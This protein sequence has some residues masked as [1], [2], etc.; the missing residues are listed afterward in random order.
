MATFTITS[1]T[2]ID[3]L[4]GKAGD[5]TYNVN[6]GKLTIDQDSLYGKNGGYI[7][8][9]TIGSIS[10]GGDITIDGRYI[11]LIPYNTGSGNVP[12]YN[13]TI[14]QGSSSGI[15]IGV[16]SALNAAP[17]TPGS[18]MP[19]S[20]YIK[21]KQWNS[22]AYTAG[23]LTGISANATAADVAGW[24]E[25]IGAET[26]TITINGLNNLTTPVISGEWYYIG[27][28]PGTPARTDTYQIPTN[29]NTCFCPGVFVET[30][31]GSGVYKIWHSTSDTATVDKV[32]TDGRGQRVC[33]VSSG[34]VLRFGHDGTN[35]TGGALP[36]A[37][38]KIR[39]GNVFLN[40][41]KS[42]TPTVNTINA[43][44]GARYDVGGASL[45]TWNMDKAMCNWYL[46]IVSYNKV[47]ITNSVIAAPIVLSTLG[48]EVT[49]MDSGYTAM[50]A[51]DTYALSLS[52]CTYGGTFT[53]LSTGGTYPSTGTGTGL[54]RAN[55]SNNVTLTESFIRST[56]TRT[57]NAD[58]IALTS[59]N[60]FE[61][62]DSAISGHIS[63]SVGVT[64]TWSNI[65]T[66]ADNEPG[67]PNDTTNYCF[68]TGAN[69]SDTL[70]ED[71]TFPYA[72]NVPN[73]IY[74]HGS[75][76]KDITFRNIGT[77]ASPI[78]GTGYTEVGASWTRV[79]TTATV[80]TSS[81]HGLVAGDKIYVY[82]TDGTSTMSLAQK[83]ILTTPTTTSFTFTCSNAGAT[84]G[85]LSFYHSAF[86]IAPFTF[87]SSNVEN[88]K[89]QNVW[90]KGNSQGYSNNSSM[91]NILFENVGI[92]NRYSGAPTLA[93][94]DVTFKGLNF[95]SGTP[96]MGAAVLGQHFFEHIVGEYGSKPDATGASWTRSAS[97]ITVTRTDHGLT[98]GDYIQ[99]RNTGSPTGAKQLCTTITVLNKDTFIYTGN[100]VGSASGTLDYRTVDGKLLIAMEGPSVTTASQVT[101]DSGT[102]K[103]TGSGSVTMF[104][105]G[106]Q[107]TW[108]LPYYSINFDHFP[109]VTPIILV[110]TG[111][112][113]TYDM[114]Y[115]L[116]RN[117]GNGFSPYKNMYVNRDSGAG[118]SGA[119]TITVD[120]TTGLAVDD[121]VW[122]A[123][124][125]AGVG[126]EAKIVSIDSS[127]QITV[128]VANAAT[129][130]SA[131][132]G[133]GYHPNEAA[134]SDD[135]FKIRFRMV[136]RTTNTG[137]INSVIIPLATT[138][139][140]RARRYPQDANTVS[141]ILSGLPTGTTVAIYDGSDVELQREDNVTSGQFVYEY[142]HN[143]TDI[144]GV[145]YVVWHEDY[146]PY[147][148]EPF[149][150][151]AIDVGLSYTPIDDTIYDPAHDDR[152][153]IDFANKLVI[154]GTGETEYD[155]PGAYSHWKDQMRLA[156][157]FIYDFAYTI[158]GGVVYSGAKEIPAFTALVNGW[159]VRPDEAD[160][161]LSAVNGILYVEGG[162]DPFVDTLGAYTV[163]INYAQPVEVLALSTSG[164]GGATASEIWSHS[165]RT[166]T[167]I[168]SSGIA[169]QTSVDAL[170]TALD[171][172]TA[173]WSDSNTYASGEKGRTLADTEANS[174]V[175]QAKVDQL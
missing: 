77:E 64:D 69:H 49:W 156:D 102:P 105:V 27:T 147:K 115:A 157:N 118:T 32:P 158:K 159:K 135:G 111:G 67:M 87:G 71:I 127:T 106:D 109:I 119:Y 169:S 47:T 21:I 78:D 155:I 161:T 81:P 83:T 24:I 74:S 56:G 23:A 25:V 148:S 139:T 22:V 76:G 116:D 31:A 41:A 134:F 52:V 10:L 29:G 57:D 165:T 96:A 117:D 20:G 8:G 4:V 140:S 144:S 40:S 44:P 62:T 48:S 167:A 72:P 17:T 59:V 146:V 98:T 61:C 128:D 131:T 43:T 5:D 7:L 88:V 82:C 58:A 129:F 14:S 103:F 91:K 2:N 12:A 95:G 145:Y 6:G 163:R 54:F 51:L 94:Y 170:P 107:I 46:S 164:G 108:E 133:F 15:L 171:N 162:G 154:M 53:R 173:V 151:T 100:S 101:V 19:A 114:T 124:G 104:N 37:G 34:G 11:R 113:T 175:T 1:D 79:T 86:T 36:G 70:V 97:T 122:N 143:G 160:H 63:R 137:A 172:A 35:F 123:P 153:T 38:C 125:I 30:S 39:V 13:T 28:T 60:N 33:W 132:L 73:Q 66:W 92:D 80:T 99:I 166:L 18:A 90:I 150:L 89:T 26:R 110:S 130:S 68:Y 3:A 42:A 84:S 138:A 50:S 168:G 65:E 16:Y 112:L 174:D 55:L 142:V 9:N 93:G 152:Y 75:S 120:D 149:D 141:F 85:I 136:T 121:Y 45:G 126:P